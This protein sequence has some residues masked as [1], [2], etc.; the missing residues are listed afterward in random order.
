MPGILTL[1]PGRPTRPP[2]RRP[3]S[4]RAPRTAAGAAPSRPP[5]RHRG[6]PCRGRHGGA[7][8][9]TRPRSP[10]VLAPALADPGLGSSVG[11][12]VRDAATGAHLFDR[13]AERP[14]IPASTTKLLTATA[15][16]ATLDPAERLSTRAVQGAAPARRRPRRR[17]GHPA[18]PRPRHAH[19]VAGRAGLDDLA[20]PDRRGAEAAR[21]RH[22]HAST[23]TTAT[24]PG[25]ATRPGGS[26]W[27]SR[28]V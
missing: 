17:R 21:R 7:A 8:A 3:A 2:R 6:R 13:D 20:A 26:R 22:R 9:G 5:R 14:G 4:R 28:P 18:G 12:T 25:P 19:A 16:M 10:A 24:P 11:V 23:W 27:T 1:D 15:V